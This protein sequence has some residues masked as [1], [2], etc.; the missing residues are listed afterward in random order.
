MSTNISQHIPLTSR[1]RN[2]LHPQQEQ[3]RTQPC[4]SLLPLPLVPQG[5]HVRVV[6]IDAGR[7]ANHR[8]TEM[9]IT[10]GTEVAILQDNG[11]ALLLAIGDTRLALGRGLAHKIRVQCLQECSQ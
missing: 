1:L 11:G 5:Q 6:E 7:Q 9:G 10:R 2:R 4:Q 3:Q 8:L